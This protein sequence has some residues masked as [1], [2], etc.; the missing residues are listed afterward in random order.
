[1][2]KGRNLSIPLLLILVACAWL[3]AS[4]RKAPVATPEQAKAHIG[5][6]AQV[7][8]PVARVHLAFKTRGQPTFIDLVRPYPHAPFTAIIWGLDRGK[9]GDPQ[10]LYLNKRVC[11]TGPITVYRGHPEIILHSP[12]QV[13]VK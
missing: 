7:C 11:V 13:A 10:Q 5:Q 1:M 2:V 6:T 3:S 9:F 12:K 4:P 8:G